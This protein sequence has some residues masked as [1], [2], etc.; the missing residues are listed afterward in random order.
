MLDGP[1]EE[2][3]VNPDDDLPLAAVEGATNG[4]KR[5]D[6][7]VEV[8]AEAAILLEADM[9]LVAPAGWKFLGAATV[10]AAESCGWG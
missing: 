3:L 1:T 9:L 6:E 10:A 7:L 4:R 8:E 2:D 5:S